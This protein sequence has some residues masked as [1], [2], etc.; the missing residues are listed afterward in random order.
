MKLSTSF[1][2]LAAF[3]GVA[4][5]HVLPEARDSNGIDDTIVLNYALTLEHLENAFYSGALSKYTQEDFVNAGF[6]AWA[7]GRIVEIGQHEAAHVAFLSDALGDKATQPCTYNF[8]YTDPKSF[9]AL[10][11]ILEGVGVSAYA[12]A[13]QYI[14]N[15]DY[16]TAAA[17]VLS[18]EARHQAWVESTL[19]HQNPWSGPLDTPLSLDAVYTLAASFITSCPSTNPSLPVQAFPSF[20]IASPKPGQ[21]SAVTAASGITTEGNYVA[22]FSGLAPI[23]VQVQNGEVAV[24]SSLMGTSYAVLT[25][26]SSS[27]ADSNV[28]AGVVVLD[29]PFN[30]RGE[31]E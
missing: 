13:A 31:L 18:T 4:S 30:S 7:R 24:P 6:P 11:S 27:A 28:V 23:F 12:G 16:L 10:S 20:A 2:S 14:S 22:F 29:F 15:K 19:L 9:V 8:P 26:S 5:S 1:I 3:L 17:A 21:C 25:N